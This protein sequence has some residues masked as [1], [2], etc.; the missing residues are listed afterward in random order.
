MLKLKAYT[1]LKIVM[2]TSPGFFFKE[3]NLYYQKDT[4]TGEPATSQRSGQVYES[5]RHYSAVSVSNLSCCR[6]KLGT[7]QTTKYQF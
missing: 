2:L 4:L 1:L 5:T 7:K 3:A 6:S